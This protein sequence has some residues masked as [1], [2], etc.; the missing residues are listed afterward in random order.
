MFILHAWK[1]GGCT[2]HYPKTSHDSTS[3]GGDGYPLYR[4]RNEIGHMV[5][6][7]MVI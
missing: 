5:M 4:R 1:D 2:K 7:H 3:T 6:K